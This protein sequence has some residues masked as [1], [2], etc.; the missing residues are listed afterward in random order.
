MDRKRQILIVSFLD[1]I[2][3]KAW[4]DRASKE[5]LLM[6]NQK[7]VPENSAAPPLFSPAFP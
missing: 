4:K 2:Q 1:C 6:P 3:H 5:I 7:I